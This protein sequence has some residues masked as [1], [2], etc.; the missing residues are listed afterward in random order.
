MSQQMQNDRAS[1]RKNIYS[2]FDLFLIAKIK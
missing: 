1:K 2:F